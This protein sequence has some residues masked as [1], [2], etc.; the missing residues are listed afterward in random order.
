M[1][2]FVFTLIAMFL[3]TAVNAADFRYSVPL[4]K[5]APE[6]YL[7][8]SVYHLLPYQTTA[9]HLAQNVNPDPFNSRGTPVQQN[10]PAV[11]AQPVI[12]QSTPAIDTTPGLLSWIFTG[13]A[14]L[15]GGAF[16][17]NQLR[18]GMQ[19][20]PEVN[21]LLLRIIESGKAGDLVQ[22]LAG[23]VPVAGTVFSA[24]RPMIRETLTDVLERRG[25]TAAQSAAPTAVEQGLETW[26][27]QLLQ[28]VG[29]IVQNRIEAALAK[30]VVS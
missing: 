7:D 1:N 6:K 27:A 20:K 9:L 8:A 21:D 10:N 4:P 16:G 28:E 2:K 12:V 11:Q 22:G 15:A 19:K 14:S 30:R 24:L 29:N 26:K 5:P 25:G 13:I 17:F 3:T 18:Q 23:T